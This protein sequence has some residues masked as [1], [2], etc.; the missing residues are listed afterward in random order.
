MRLH[1][2]IMAILGSELSSAL[3]RH[4]GDRLTQ[5]LSG[6]DGKRR[7]KSED[8]VGEMP[9]SKGIELLWEH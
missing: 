4:K 8:R 7:G 9:D 3:S 5:V 6:H 1:D 2:R